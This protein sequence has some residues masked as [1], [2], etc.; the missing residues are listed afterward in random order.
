MNKNLFKTKWKSKSFA[1][2]IIF[3]LLF[4]SNITASSQIFGISQ[5]VKNIKES[6]KSQKETTDVEIEPL[7]PL[8]K[9][10]QLKT[11]RYRDGFGGY[12]ISGYVYKNKFVEEQ[13]LIIKVSTHHISQIS[14]IKGIYFCE[15]GISYIDGYATYNLPD[16]VRLDGIFK[17]TNNE[18]N[19][20]STNDI[21]SKLKVETSS[22]I[23]RHWE[24]KYK[25]TTIYEDIQT[26][27][28]SA[29]SIICPNQIVEFVLLKQLDPPI[30]RFMQD[31]FGK[32]NEVKLTFTPK[33]DI[34]VGTVGID[35]Y[36]KMRFFPKE[37]EYKYST[38]E[39][40][41]GTFNNYNGIRIPE[42]GKMIYADGSSEDFNYNNKDIFEA[43]ADAKNTNISPT[44]IRDNLKIEKQK[45]EIEKREKEA[46][47][48]KEWEKERK[49]KALRNQSLIAKYGE[50]VGNLLIQK[51]LALG[52][53]KEMVKEVVSEEFCEKSIF[54]I[55]NN[56]IETW[57]F[58]LSSAAS[59]AR[60]L[61]AYSQAANLASQSQTLVFT[62]NKLTAIY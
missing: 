56:V 61:G 4:L 19:T 14:T 59:L 18:K 27:G 43:F 3:V 47:R 38:G 36:S 20:L 62:N 17:I 39:I 54:Q 58:N 51:K 24:D 22:I 29:I 12:E 10:A 5:I 1:V 50:E 16:L 2:I 21:Y 13:S 28:T 15:E 9:G 49:Q 44:E 48:Q 7:A 42:K 31:Y 32:Q 33:N 60:E 6:R 25:K 52:M 35:G 45:Q 53:T 8:P 40:F 23:S 34:F 37:G 30:D 46:D 57:Y 41:T 55:G 26:D 11:I